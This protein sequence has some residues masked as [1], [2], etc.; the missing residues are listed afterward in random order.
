M[1]WHTQDF[2]MGEFCNRHCFY[3]SYSWNL[4]WRGSLQSCWSSLSLTNLQANIGEEQKKGLPVL[5][6]HNYRLFCKVSFLIN[7]FY[8]LLQKKFSI[9]VKA[10]FQYILQKLS[11]PLNGLIL[12]DIIKINL[13]LIGV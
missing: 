2:F 11:G 1:Q 9:E 12:I 13:Q 5:E 7:A 4:Q 6:A 8:W 10:S 3:S